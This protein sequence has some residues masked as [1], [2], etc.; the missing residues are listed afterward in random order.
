MSTVPA[1]GARAQIMLILTHVSDTKM[2][3]NCLISVSDVFFSQLS[4]M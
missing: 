3:L 4:M 2:Y 1:R